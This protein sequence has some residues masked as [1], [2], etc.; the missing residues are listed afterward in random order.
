MTETNNPSEQQNGEVE[1]SGVDLARVA[2][3]QAREAAKARGEQ[4]GT[5]KAKRRT[6]TAAAR[7]DGREPA[8]FAAVLQAL[9]ADRA[10]D[11]E[12]VGSVL[13][14]WPAIVA[15]VSLTLPAHVAAVAFHA[16]TGQLDLRPDSP[17]GRRRRRR[18]ATVARS[19]PTRPARRPLR[20]IRRFRRR[21]AANQGAGPRA[22]AV[23]RRRAGGHR[24]TARTRGPHREG[25]VG[26]HQLAPL[27]TP[28]TWIAP[29]RSA[30]PQH[31][32]YRDRGGVVGHSIWPNSPSMPRKP[33]R[34]LMQ[35]RRGVPVQLRKVIVP[36]GGLHDGLM[37]VLVRQVEP[38]KVPPLWG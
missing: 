22:G 11:I 26:R 1:L 31:R 20:P 19:P 25:V 24:G 23:L 6:R 12:A 30:V 7:R 38:P 9:M 37:E 35:R 21:G 28:P 13:D 4:A 29:I 33:G 8:G 32:G 14:Q 2:L 10:W 3:H 17:S 34:R 5:R 27:S 15:A 18:R 36:V 16:E